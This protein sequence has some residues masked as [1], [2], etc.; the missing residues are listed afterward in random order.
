[1][2]TSSFHG[3]ATEQ[4]FPLSIELADRTTPSTILHS[5]NLTHHK[6]IFTY[7]QTTRMVHNI[8]VF[9]QTSMRQR[10]GEEISLFC[11]HTDSDIGTPAHT[12]C[13]IPATAYTFFMARNVQ[14]VLKTGC[15][16]YC[17]RVADARIINARFVKSL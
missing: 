10:C 2:G 11:S 3:L 17:G 1:M 12:T 4:N 15:I 8:I 6:D 7:T 16:R 14:Q 13:K 9:L 5:E